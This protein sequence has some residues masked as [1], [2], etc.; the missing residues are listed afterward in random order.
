MACAN[1]SDYNLGGCNP[2]AALDP[3]NCAVGKKCIPNPGANTV[4]FCAPVVGDKGYGEACTYN[5]ESDDCAPGF[6]CM[7]DSGGATGTCIEQCGCGPETPTCSDGRVCTQI[8]GG[9]Y[10]VC[11]DNCDP[12]APECFGK[13]HCVMT[14]AGFRCMPKALNPGGQGAPCE[15]SI[16]CDPGFTCVMCDG[17]LCCAKYCEDE[18]DCGQQEVCG[19]FQPQDD[20]Y[21]HVGGCSP[22]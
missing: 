11:L 9:K 7:L 8:N 17:G 21:P 5:G 4:P 18:L 2:Y 12:L 22:G 16:D 19:M 10:P 1:P 20:C 15:L 6:V 13:M 14:L 3:Q